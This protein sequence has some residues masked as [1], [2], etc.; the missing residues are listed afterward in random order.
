MRDPAEEGL[1]AAAFSLTLNVCLAGVK[2]AAGVLGNSYALVADGIESTAD[3]LSTLVVWGGIR[4]SRRPPDRT[5]PYGHGKAESMAAVFVA[6]ILLAAAVFIA[7]RS[8]QEIVT[9]HHAPAAFTLLVLVA[10]VLVKEGMFRFLSR[11]GAR[12]HSSSL[13]ADAWHHRSDALTSAAAF[14]G[15]SVA[16]LGGEGWE[17][18]DDWAAL[19]ACT[20]IAWNGFRLL[21]PAVDEVMDATVPAETISEIRRLA[22]GVPG[23]VTVEKCRVR[24]SGLGYLMDIHVEVDPEIPVRE[25]HAIGHRV[26]DH[27]KGSRLPIDDVVVH[28]EPAGAEHDR[29]ERPA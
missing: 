18:A 14:V 22:A 9:P 6:S 10:V 27:L 25:G 29:S 15:I 16:L 19:A 28:V 8:V 20:V 13:A 12:V 2:I 26:A 7:V 3:I 4:I 21:R 17:S 11:T 23:V 1:R 5:H 24:K